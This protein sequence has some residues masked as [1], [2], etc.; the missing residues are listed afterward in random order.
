MDFFLRSR[1][2]FVFVSMACAALLL[3]G[4]F[5]Q[6]ALGL[7]PCPLC[8]VQRIFFVA[9]GGVSFAAALH[10]PGKRWIGI[11]SAMIS[12]FAFLGI[13]AAG[14]QVWL[15]HFPPGLGTTCSPFLTS[16]VDMLAS[17][18]GGSG[19]C[20]ERGWTLLGLSI[21]EWALLSFL[22]FLGAGIAQWIRSRRRMGEEI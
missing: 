17:V 21:P 9:I 6:H 2:V 18:F 14:R 5:L 19:D 8:I 7:I 22:F 4:V 13:T 12:V 3:I 20:A 11:Y 16:I 10:N 1:V 15:Q